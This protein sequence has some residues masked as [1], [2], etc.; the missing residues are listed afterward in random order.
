[1]E[2]S[3]MEIEGSDGRLR[4]SYVAG[5]QRSRCDLEDI[6]KTLEELKKMMNEEEVFKKDAPGENIFE[7][8]R[9]KLKAKV[10][11]YFLLCA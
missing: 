7:G 3:N 1:M 11:N 10:V 4:K 6:R 2:D 5:L 8:E 9:R